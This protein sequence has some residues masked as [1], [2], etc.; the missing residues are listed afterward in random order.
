MSYRIENSRRAKRPDGS[1]PPARF[2]RRGN[3]Q[4]PVRGNGNGVR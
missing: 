2:A 3:Y 4:L 1:R